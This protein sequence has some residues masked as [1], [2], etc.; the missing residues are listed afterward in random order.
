MDIEK[1]QLKVHQYFIHG[2]D[3]A[4]KEGTKLVAIVDGKV[5]KTGWNGAGGFTIVISSGEYAFSR[6]LYSYIC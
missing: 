2:I 5:T 6:S 4:A 1:H 3:I